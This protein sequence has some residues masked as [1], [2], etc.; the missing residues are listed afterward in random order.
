MGRITYESRDDIPMADRRNIVLSTDTA[1]IASGCSVTSS[2][3]A[4]LDIAED[5]EDN[6]CF[7]MGGA[8]LFNEAVPVADKMYITI[9][10]ET[11]SGDVK[12]PDKKPV[13]FTHH[14]ITA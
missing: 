4:A 8:S 6:E 10:R 5:A 12:F 11:F 9:V 14:L 3:Q 2:L 1:Y 7:I 13:A